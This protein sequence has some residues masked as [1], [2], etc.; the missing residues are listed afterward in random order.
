VADWALAN[1]VTKKD[2]ERYITDTWLR[3]NGRWQIVATEI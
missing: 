1:N 2:A 3:W